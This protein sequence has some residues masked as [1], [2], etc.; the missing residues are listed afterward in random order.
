M[1]IDNTVIYIHGKCAEQ[2]AAKLAS[3]MENVSQWFNDSCLTL[4]VGKTVSM[5]LCQSKAAGLSRHP[6]TCPKNL[7]CFRI[8]YLGIILE[9]S[10]TLNKTHK[11]NYQHNPI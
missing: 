6:H 9:P 7:N 2:V 11:R 4:N 1:Y 8:Q 3:V 10:L 5:Y